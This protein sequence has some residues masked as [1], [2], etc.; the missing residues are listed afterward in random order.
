MKKIVKKSEVLREGQITALKTVAAAIRRA[1][2][3]SGAED[4]GDDTEAEI[5]ET[6]GEIEDTEGEGT[7]QRLFHIAMTRTVTSWVEVRA[8]SL[9]D[10]MD[11]CSIGIGVKENGDLDARSDYE[12]Y[13]E[14]WGADSGNDEID[15]DECYEVIED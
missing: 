2:N 12:D 4:I 10:A 11:M 6:E 13:V 14:N 5:E 8:E 15:V 3:E 9:D 1:L 7:G